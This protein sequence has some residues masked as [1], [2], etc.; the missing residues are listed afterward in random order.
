M[1]S[2]RI[3]AASP[4]IRSLHGLRCVSLA[5]ARL[6]ILGSMP[7][8][9]SLRRQAYYANPHNHFWRVVFA[10]LGE[11]DPIEYPRRLEALTRRGIALWDVLEACQRAGSLDANIV[12]GS[13]V[14]NDIPGFLRAHPRV[15][16]VA[17]NGA[18]AAAL[19]DR[20]IIARWGDLSERIQILRLPSTSPANTCGIER[21][22][23]RWRVVAESV[24][25]APRGGS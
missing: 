17:L 23:A 11:T 22:I 2:R 12:A 8:A 15:R 1:P 25:E 5:S 4:A 18:K 20:L 14:A 16:A 6:L 3:V 19:F 9:E 13:E 24:G 10:V 21:K 7:S